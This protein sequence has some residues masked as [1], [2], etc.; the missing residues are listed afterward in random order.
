M[1]K[2]KIIESTT[3]DY[4]APLHDIMGC[5]KECYGQLE[6]L[7]ETIPAKLQ[8]AESSLKDKIKKAKTKQVKAKKALAE[9]KQK[10]KTKP[11]AANQQRLNKCEDALSDIKAHIETLT[12][13]HAPLAEQVKTCATLKI[14]HAAITK[15]VKKAKADLQKKEMAKLKKAAKKSKTKKKSTKTEH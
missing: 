9:A 11:S 12:T 7:L 8:K 3:T 4:L 14:K 1:P 6:K 13:E 15:A 5:I 2:Q 10:Q